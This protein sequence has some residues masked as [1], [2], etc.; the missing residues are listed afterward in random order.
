[1][2]VITL[3][4]AAGTPA[5]PDWSREFPGRSKA[6][7][8]ER[9]TASE[10]W[11]AITRELRSLNR[12]A[13]VNGHS[14]K[15]LVVA[16]IMYD[17]AAAQ[18]AKSGAVLKSPRTGTPMHSPWFTVMIQAGKMAASIE[19]ELA[20]SPRARDDGAPIPAPPRP[21]TGADRYLR[22][23]NL[24]PPAP[25]SDDKPEKEDPE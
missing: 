24:L 11:G 25:P 18:V 7:E 3:D 5:E 9:V 6:M 12:L 21:R 8:A 1:L 13:L 22:G 4:A 10:Y 14:V 2:N 15:R 17:R 20:I 19:T 16:W 23:G